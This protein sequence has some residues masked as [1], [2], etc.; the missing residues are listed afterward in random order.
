MATS[1]AGSRLLAEE[2]RRRILEIIEQKGQ[3]TIPDLVRRFSVSAVTARGDLDALS[4]TGAV[5][6][7]H[8][9]AVRHEPTR[10][11]PLPL[12]ATMHR[13][14]KTRIGQA[15]GEL[16]Q[17]NETVILDSG[18]TTAEIARHL[19]TRKLQVRVIT[20]AMNIAMELAN[21][22]EVTVTVICGILR[23]VSL[24]FVGPQAETMVKELHADKLFLGVDGMDAETG[25][26]TPDILEAQ[27]NG[28]MVRAAREVN[29]VAD[30]SKLGHRSVCRICPMESVRRLITDKR[31]PAE[32][33]AALRNKGIEVVQV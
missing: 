10:D 5:M 21:A 33:V 14:E 24:S 6:R 20:N 26:S 9:G 19:K 3:I 32:F 2:R 22:P 23:P 12:K 8:G 16:V 17:P 7:S 15:A 11:Y 1:K 29:V 13:P 31:A 27:L 28:W 18:T 30:S 4:T 25:P